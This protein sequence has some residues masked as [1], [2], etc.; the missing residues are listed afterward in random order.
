MKKDIEKKDTIYNMV[1]AGLSNA[2]ISSKLNLAEVTVK[3]YITK[4]FIEHGVQSRS[5]LIVKHY[6]GQKK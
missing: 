4:L 2:E 6:T 3:G 5:R 1:V